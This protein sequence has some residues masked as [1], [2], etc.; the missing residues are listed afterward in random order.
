[1]EKRRVE[2]SF[3]IEPAVGR[4][5]VKA[6]SGKWGRDPKDTLLLDLTCR[7]PLVDGSLDSVRAGLDVGYDKAVDTFLRITPTELQE[8]WSPK[9]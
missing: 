8:R 2:W 9:T 7:G 6:Q 3:E 1:M 4:L 5:H